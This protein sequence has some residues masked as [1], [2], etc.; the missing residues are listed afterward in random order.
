MPMVIAV[1]L[2]GVPSSLGVGVS[3][4]AD[5]FRS[6]RETD[7]K[8]KCEWFTSK[9]RAAKLFSVRFRMSPKEHNTCLCIVV[10]QSPLLSTVRTQSE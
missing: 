4:G 9:T 10:A 7:G 6:S 5:C 8:L 3:R 1:T 2:D